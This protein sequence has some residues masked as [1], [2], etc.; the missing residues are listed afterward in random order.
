M[1]FSFFKG[2]QHL[3]AVLNKAFS[4]YGV[5]GGKI[6]CVKEVSKHL[7]LL[8][9]LTKLLIGSKVTPHYSKNRSYVIHHTICQ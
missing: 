6:S 2:K 7:R 4:N 5:F 3:F 8:E 1:T 9:K